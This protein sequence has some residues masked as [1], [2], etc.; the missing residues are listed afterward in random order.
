MARFYTDCPI[1][2]DRLLVREAYTKSTLRET[3]REF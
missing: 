2:S 1:K 3:L